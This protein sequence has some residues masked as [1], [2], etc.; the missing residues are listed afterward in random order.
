MDD[1]LFK[2][3]VVILL[4]AGVISS[5]ALIGY[6]IHLYGQCSILNYIANER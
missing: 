3:V 5:A 1:K 4:A 2:R 6:T